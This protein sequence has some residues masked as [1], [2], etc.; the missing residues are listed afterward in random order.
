[1][2]LISLKVGCAAVS[3]LLVVHFQ[4]LLKCSNIIIQL[5]WFEH[6]SSIAIY[7]SLQ[8]GCILVHKLFLYYEHRPPSPDTATSKSWLFREKKYDLYDYN[9]AVVCVLLS[10]KATRAAK[11]RCLKYFC[12]IFY[13]RKGRP[14]LR[15]LHLQTYLMADI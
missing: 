2:S 13:W 11:I 10:S 1:M 8:L 14:M 4:K 6:S 12:K 3:P 5:L 9:L 15:K 7:K